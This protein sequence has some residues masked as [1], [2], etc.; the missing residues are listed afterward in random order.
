[1]FRDKQE[2]VGQTPVLLLLN[3]PFLVSLR[4][5]PLLKTKQTQTYFSVLRHSLAVPLPHTELQIVLGELLSVI[6][7]E[8][9]RPVLPVRSL[10]RAN[11]NLLYPP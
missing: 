3:F 7:L 4:I 11:L 5:H 9:I 8:P 10:L 6:T 2:T 1:M